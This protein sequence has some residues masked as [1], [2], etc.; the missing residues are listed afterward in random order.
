MIRDTEKVFFKKY[1]TAKEYAAR[2]KITYAAATR[3]LKKLHADG[4]LDAQLRTRRLSEVTGPA[5]RE[6]INT[7]KGA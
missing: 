7:L 4:W 2:F 6:F 3:R 1:R 5:A